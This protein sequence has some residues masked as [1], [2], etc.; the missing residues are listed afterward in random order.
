MQKNIWQILVIAVGLVI[1]WTT[2]QAR[3]EAIEAQA[4]SNKADIGII[5]DHLEIDN[6]QEQE[7]YTELLVTLE[8]LVTKVEG[9]EKI[10]SEIKEEL[11]GIR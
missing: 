2:F 1:S 9:I 11:N 5:A 3:V 8:K 4:Q 6:K 7:R 10:T